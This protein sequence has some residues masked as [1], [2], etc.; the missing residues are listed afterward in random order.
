MGCFEMIL[1]LKTH[2]MK[3]I[4][5]VISVI[6]LMFIV[7]SCNKENDSVKDQSV[8]QINANIAEI[9]RAHV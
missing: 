6:A 5:L 8:K 9:G 1:N 4:M 2:Q 3:K 7:N